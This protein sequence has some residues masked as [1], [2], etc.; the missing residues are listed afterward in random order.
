MKYLKTYEQVSENDIEVGDYVI[1]REEFIPRTQLEVELKDF[2]STNI[3]KYIN[4][5]KSDIFPYIIKYYNVPEKFKYRY[6]DIEDCRK[7]NRGEIYC[8]SK[9]PKDLEIYV[10]QN[11]Y[12]V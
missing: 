4:Y 12:N 8:W 6:F 1:A 10:N 3:G 2:T 5:E 9:D 11:I 7:L